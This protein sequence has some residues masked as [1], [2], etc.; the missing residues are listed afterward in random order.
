MELA[1]DAIAWWCWFD[2]DTDA[3]PVEVGV[4]GLLEAVLVFVGE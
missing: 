3:G 1:I 4:D 2:A